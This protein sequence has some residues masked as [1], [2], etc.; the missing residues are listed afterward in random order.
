MLMDFDQS[1]TQIAFLDCKAALEKQQAISVLL[2]FAEIITE[3]SRKG[4]KK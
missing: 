1:F 4:K 2:R 3:L